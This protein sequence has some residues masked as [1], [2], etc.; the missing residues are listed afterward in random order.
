MASPA[1]SSPNRR[2]SEAEPDLEYQMR[3]PY[4][5]EDCHRFVPAPDNGHHAA[6]Y[7]Y[8][9]FNGLMK[10]IRRVTPQSAT[11]YGMLAQNRC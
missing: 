8:I 6:C 1:D 3:H 2:A 10:R 9:A 11:T 5:P 7:P 4:T